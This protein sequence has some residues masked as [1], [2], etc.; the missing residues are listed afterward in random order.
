M[1]ETIETIYADT[2]IFIRFFTGYP[3]EQ[4]ELAH[5]F[6]IE[7]SLKKAK[8]FVCDIVI[9]EIVYVLEKIYK[10]SRNEIYEK[11][12]SILNME[13]IIIENRAIIANALNYYKKKNINFND[14]YLASY[15]IKN[16]INKVFTFDSD[17]KKNEEIN[18]I[19]S[20]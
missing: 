10:L 12:H 11:I 15:A 7:V 8:L 3:E 14:A 17:F 19:N 18:I 4:S 13:N 6:F 2:N 16:N 1:V 20:I 9:S 5:R